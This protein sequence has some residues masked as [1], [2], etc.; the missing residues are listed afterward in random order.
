ML[1]LSLHYHSIGIDDWWRRWIKWTGD[2]VVGASTG[3]DMG[4]SSEG[5]HPDDHFK[6]HLVGNSRDPELD[7]GMVSQVQI[8]TNA[9]WWR[10]LLSAN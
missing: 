7:S 4:I 9:G 5:D 8:T 3:A 6:K 1:V 10:F 2:V